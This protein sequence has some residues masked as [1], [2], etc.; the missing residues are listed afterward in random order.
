MTFERSSIEERL[1]KLRQLLQNL[2]EIRAIPADEFVADYRH[3][4]LAERGLQLA[5][6]T[7]L[8]IAHHILAAVYGRYPETNEE[9]LDALHQCQVIATDLHAQLQGF[10]GLRNVL[11]HGYLEIDE[12]QVYQHLQ[13]APD[14]L[15]RFCAEV[16]TWMDNH[17][18]R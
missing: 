5:A 3:Y 2:E 8:D 11:V 10:G 18:R 17:D 6:E 1:K 7:V 4:W 12:A 13:K 15:R 14:V 9:A 16:I